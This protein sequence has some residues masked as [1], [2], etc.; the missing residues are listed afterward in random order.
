MKKNRSDWDVPVEVVG[1]LTTVFFLPVIAVLAFCL[2]PAITAVTKGNPF[3]L[4]LWGL[5]SGAF[6]VTALFR[7]RWP[8]YRQGRFWTFGP[9][10]LDQRHVR[11]YWVA[12]TFILVSIFLLVMV[13]F[14]T[15]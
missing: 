6:G 9:R 11:L 12:H 10:E 15:R 5:M 1:L 14:R 2:L 8:L 4:Y 7:A 3:H 13:W